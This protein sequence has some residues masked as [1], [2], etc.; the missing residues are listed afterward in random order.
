MTDDF[1]YVCPDSELDPWREQ[2]AAARRINARQAAELGFD[3]L[4][5]YGF[6]GT[7]SGEHVAVCQRCAAL[8]HYPLPRDHE[9][10]REWVKSTE[11]LLRHLRSVHGIEEAPDER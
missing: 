11:P 9:V 4:S 5:P 8:V 7:D 1:L 6:F 10:S 3:D 2:K